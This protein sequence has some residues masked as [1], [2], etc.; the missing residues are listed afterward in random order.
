MAME[1]SNVDTIYSLLYFL[2]QKFGE[3]RKDVKWTGRNPSSDRLTSIV[4][5]EETKGPLESQFSLDK[6]QDVM[7]MSSIIQKA[8][9]SDMHYAS[10]IE[11]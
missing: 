5:R 8:W 2:E 6:H 1:T 3:T 10:F 11:W 7:N 9:L 4:N